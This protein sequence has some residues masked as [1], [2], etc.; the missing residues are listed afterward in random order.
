MPLFWKRYE[1][2]SKEVNITHEVLG[3]LFA[4]TRINIISTKNRAEGDIP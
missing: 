1:G 2:F 4:M 3:E